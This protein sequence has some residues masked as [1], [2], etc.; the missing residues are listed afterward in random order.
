M[1]GLLLPLFA[2]GLSLDD[3]RMCRALV[4][5]RGEERCCGVSQVCSRPG[6]EQVT[7]RGLG[8]CM[9][10]AAEEHVA[11]R[12]RGNG[13]S[14]AAEVLAAAT[15]LEASPAESPAARTKHGL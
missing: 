11:K 2:A 13:G 7:K 4:T 3:S 15:C 9:Q 6:G 12:A 1:S 5:C 14:K 10:H 8:A